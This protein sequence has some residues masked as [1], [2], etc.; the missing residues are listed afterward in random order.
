MKA[1]GGSFTYLFIIEE[2]LPH[3]GDDGEEFK[4]LDY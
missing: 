1:I 2:I 4:N 3:N